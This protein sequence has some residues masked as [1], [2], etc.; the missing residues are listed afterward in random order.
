[1]SVVVPIVVLVVDGREG[2]RLGADEVR[3]VQLGDDVIGGGDDCYPKKS[4]R[5]SRQV[6]L[7]T[8]HG[9]LKRTASQCEGPRLTERCTPERRSDHTSTHRWRR[10]VASACIGPQACWGQKRSQGRLVE[11]LR[12]VSFGIRPS[13]LRHSTSGLFCRCCGGWR[14]GQHVG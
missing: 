13:L 1:M 8:S 4:V 9:T 11:K 3:D 14:V 12:T 7:D 6:L 10:L 5:A 2:E